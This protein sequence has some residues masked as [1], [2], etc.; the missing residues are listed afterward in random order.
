MAQ[1]VGRE[2]RMLAA[3]GTS[4]AGIVEYITVYIITSAL[5]PTITE[6]VTTFIELR[7]AATN[8]LA[9]RMAH[10]ERI[11]PISDLSDV[12]PVASAA[13]SPAAHKIK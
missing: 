12:L 10:I 9:L 7:F 4:D 5:V 3:F 6:P 8:Q 13:A 2:K 11:S 1:N